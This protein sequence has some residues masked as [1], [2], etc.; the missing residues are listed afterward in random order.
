MHKENLFQPIQRQ[1]N[2]HQN[3]QVRSVSVVNDKQFNL[4]RPAKSETDA[5]KASAVNEL[6]QNE[7]VKPSVL[8]GL[9]KI[10]AS[11]S[12]ILNELNKTDTMKRS[13]LDESKTILNIKPFVSNETA[14]TVD[15]KPIISHE[16]TQIYNASN[17]L[18]DRHESQNAVAQPSTSQSMIDATTNGNVLRNNSVKVDK[19]V[20]TLTDDDADDENI[21]KSI[22][23]LASLYFGDV[24]NR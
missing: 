6:R 16:P 22:D 7:T 19:E 17:K 13:I 21:K 18:I 11:K 15:A 14:R 24:S 12:P 1:I 10:D 20:G 8:N 5:S 9:S 23:S 3:Q 2:W 4:N